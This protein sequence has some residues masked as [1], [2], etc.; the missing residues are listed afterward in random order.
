MSNT[1]SI[2]RFIVIAFLLYI[3]WFIVYDYFIQPDGR[4]NKLLD[5]LLALSASALLKL[6]GYNAEVVFRAENILI[7]LDAKEMLGVGD[8]CNGLELFILFAGFIICFPGNWIKKLWFVLLGI[9]AIH[10]INSVRAA[11]LTLNQFYHPQSLEF[12]HHY[13]FT[14]VVYTF[15]F[16][17]WYLWV[18]KFTKSNQTD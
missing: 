4:L 6:I 11:I 10:L 7:A 5:Y 12:N 16:Y 13:T 9:L 18:N 8:S 14:M 15:I 1:R 3:L 2:I 17:L